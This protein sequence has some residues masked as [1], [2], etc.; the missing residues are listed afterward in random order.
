MEHKRQNNTSRRIWDKLHMLCSKIPF[1]QNLLLLSLSIYI[2]IS[3]FSV[4]VH[5]W[6]WRWASVEIS[7]LVPAVS[8]GTAV[9][10]SMVSLCRFSFMVHFF[11][12]FKLRLVST[13]PR[14]QSISVHSIVTWS[15]HVI[16]LFR[17]SSS[18]VSVCCSLSPINA[19]LNI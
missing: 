1:K 17:I 4:S 8:Y 19:L 9:L 12:C 18:V 14:W 10:I 2:Y 15:N 6:S 5:A 7:P 13:N 11:D 3:L 16:L